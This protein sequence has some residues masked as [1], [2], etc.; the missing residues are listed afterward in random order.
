MRVFWRELSA[1]TLLSFLLAPG[2]GAADPAVAE[3]LSAG[4]MNEAIRVLTQRDDPES[5]HLLSR[6]YYAIEDWDEAVR[7]GERAVAL[8]PENA[9]YHLWLARQ[10]GQKAATSNPLRAAGIAR[11]AKTE[12]ERAVMLD[13]ANVQGHADL[14]EYYIEAPAIMGG[15]LEKARDQAVQVRQ[16]DPAMSHWILGRVAEREKRWDDAEREYRSGTKVAKDPAEYWLHVAS[17]YRERGRLD[18]MQQLVRMAV[19]QPNK[20]AET[21]YN[22]ATILYEG[23]RDFPAAVQYL[24]QYLASGQMA[25]DALAFRAHYLLGQL[26]EGMGNRPAAIEQYQAALGLASGFSPARAALSRVQ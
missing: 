23:G 5:L 10:Y 21:Y 7:N 8:R 14:A 25:E 13:P 26:Y 19:A 11:K 17:L 22:A 3:L 15:G 4:R 9:G 16:Y 1:A 24:K 2:I 12:F 6:A 18:E 20:G